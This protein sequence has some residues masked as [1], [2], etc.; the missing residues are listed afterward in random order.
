[1][2]GSPCCKDFS[3][4][5]RSAVQL[6]CKARLT[7]DEGEVI[8]QSQCMSKGSGDDRVRISPDV[9]NPV[10]VYRFDSSF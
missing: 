4:E 10:K 8:L 5:A 1:M 2:P 9:P 6:F 3:D 7:H